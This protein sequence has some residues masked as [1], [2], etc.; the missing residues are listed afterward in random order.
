V[1]IAGAECA[2]PGT[3]RHGLIFKNND[4]LIETCFGVIPFAHQVQQHA[5]LRKTCRHIQ[6][7]AVAPGKPDR[8][9]VAA[10]GT[11]EPLVRGNFPA[12]FFGQLIEARPQFPA[13]P[14]HSLFAPQDTDGTVGC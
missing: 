12:M 6:D 2:L 14:S 9:Q 11:L 1:V 7:G 10:L 3:L 5:E 4:S 8:F 13:T